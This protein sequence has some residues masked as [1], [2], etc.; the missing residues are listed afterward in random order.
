MAATLF[1]SF[2]LL[3]MIKVPVSFSLAISSAL[4]LILAGNINPA[5]IVQRMYTASESFSLIAIPFF[6]LAGGFMETGGISKRLVKFASTL[7]GHI[8]GGLSMVSIVAAMFFAGISGSTA[9]DTAAIGSI[10]I[11]AMEKKGR[12]FH[13]HE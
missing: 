9:A 12:I 3:L 4:A 7:V 10:L 8:R 6:I 5:V 13:I 11:P 2:I 1:I